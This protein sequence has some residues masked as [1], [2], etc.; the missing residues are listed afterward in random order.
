[1]NKSYKSVWNESTG[2]YV[3]A[4]EVAKSRGK[5]NK[6]NKLIVAALLAAGAVGEVYAGGIDGGTVVKS[7]QEAIGTGAM[8]TANTNDLGTGVAIGSGATSS[9]TYATAIGGSSTAAGNQSI[10]LGAYAQTAANTTNATAIGFGANAAGAYA[11]AIGAQATSS[12]AYATALG[13]GSTASGAQGIALGGYAKSAAGTTNASAIG[14]NANAAGSEAIALGAQAASS[15][16]W[17]AAL[18]DASTASG[19]QS[20]AVGAYANTAAGATNGVALGFAASA[21]AASG[22]A[23][24]SG[25]TASGSAAVAVGSYAAATAANSVALGASSTTTADLT[26]AAYNPGSGTLSGTASKANGEVSVG[27]AGKERRVTNVAAGSAATDAVNVSQLA[28]EDA[29]VNAINTMVTNNSRYFKAG[30]LQ[31]GTDDASVSG[32]SVAVGAGASALSTT[33]QSNPTAY[34]NSVAMGNQAKAAGGGAIAIGDHANSNF[35]DIAIGAGA[36]TTNARQA[37]ALGLGATVSGTTGVAV[38]F[39]ASAAAASSLA[40]GTSSTSKGQSAIALGSSSSAA[41]DYTFAAGN[42]ASAVGAGDIALGASS[43]ASGGG[44]YATALGTNA[45]AI[46]ANAVA[47]GNAAKATATNSVALGTGS[48]TTANLTA[49]GYNPG[50]STL[51][52]TA[53][54]ANGEVSVGSAGKER[55]VTNV[56]AGSAATDAVNVSQ[57]KS[58]DAKVNADGTATASALGGGASYD[59]ST[60]TIKAPTYVV[61][62]G[63]FSDVGSAL[64]KLDGATTKNTGDISTLNTTVNNITNGTAGLVQQN[65]TTHA[66]TVASATAGTTVDFTGTAGT[67]QLKGVSAGTANTDAVNVA[68]LKAAGLNVDTSGNATNAFVA[69][70]DTSKG[71]VTLAGGASGTTITDVKA[72]ALSASSMDAVNGSQ[73]YATNTNVTNLQNTVNNINNGT[74]GLV[75]QNATTKVITVASATDGALVDFTG[76]KGARQL[77]GVSKGAVNASSVD[78]INGSQ[79]FAAS[80][81][82]AAALGGGAAVN[83]DGSVKAPTY[84]I[85]GS[86]YNNVGDALTAAASVGAGVDPNAVAYNDGSKD[87]VTLKGAEGTTLSNVKAGVADMD[88]VNVAQLKAAGLN[89]DDSGNVTNAFVAYDD[90]TKAQVTLGGATGTTIS[91]VKAGV[92]D[93]D[94]VNVSQLK[95][96]D[97]RAQ[98]GINGLN[99]EMATVKDGIDG[100]AGQVAQNTDGINGLNG[101]MATVKDGINGLNGQMASVQNGI[102]GLN[103]DMTNVVKYDD[104]S[105]GQI[106]LDGANGTTIANVKAGVADMDAVNVSQ[107]KDVDTRAQDGING[108]NGEMATVKDGIDGLA[109]QVAQNTDGIN[110]LNGQMASVQNGIDGLNADMTNVVKYDDASHGQISLDGANGTTI[111]NV[112]AGVADMDAVNVSQLKDVD[113]RAQDGINGLNGEMASVK[114]GI[115]GLAGQVAQN[116]DGINGLNGQMASVQNGIDGLNADMTNVVK[117]DDAS[118]G[119]ITLDGANGTTIANV[120]A[121]VADMDAVNVSQLKDVDT[122]AQD[123]ING[124]NG[125][126]ATVKDGIDGLNGQMASV[127]NGI[128]GLNGEVGKNT[129]DITNIT[130]QINNGEIG[131]VQQDATSRNITVAANTD[132]TVV[133][134]TGTA[135]T[136]QLKGVSEGTADTDAVN[137]SQL[138]A[139]G[140]NVDTSGNVTNAFVAYDDA[141]KGQVTLGG[142]TGTTIS[143]VKA[144]VADM[145]AVNVSQLKDVDTRAQDG[146]N[147]L[148]GQMASVQNGID[149]INAD[150]TNVVKY[151]DA[152]HGQITLDGANGTTIANVKAGVADMDAVNVAQLK[153]AGLNTDDSGNVTNAFVAYDDATK[154]QVTLGGDAGTTISNVKAGVADMDAVNVA[155][156]KDVDTR[157]QDGINGLNGEM[158]SVKD[159]IDGLN[160]QMASV[161]NGI[162][163]LNGEV[164]KN[165]GDITNITNQINNGEIGL[166]QQD[167]T[168]RNITVA[169][170][171]DGTVVDFTGTAGTRQLKGVSEGTADTDAVNVAQLKAAGLNVDTSGNVTNAFV[172]YDDA[173]KGQI[174]LG[175]ATGTTISNVKAGVADMDAVN[176]AQLKDVDTRAQ[177]GINGLNGE[178]ASV[179]DGIDGLAGQVAQ[180][181]DGINGLNADM[182]SVKD[183]IN[184]INADIANAVKYDDASHGQITLDGANGTTIANVKAGVA[185]MDAVN[186]AQLKDVDTRAQDGIN[187]LNGQMASVQDGINGLNGQM[188][189]VQNGI[190]GIN[191]DMT[192]VVKYDDASHG[193]ITLDGANG[194]TIS[195]V[196]AG[197]ADMDAVNVAQLKAA[198]LNTD[199]SGNVTN[200]FVAYDDATKGQVTLGGD[201]GTT[202]SNVKAGIAD[203]DAV[204]VAQLKDV[205]TRAQDGIN[206]LNGEMATVKDGI[207]GLAGQVAQNT[208]GINGLNADMASVK[209]GINGINADIANAVKYDDASHGQIS[210]DGAN[211]TTIANVK[212]GVAD[213][214][215][216][217]VS[218]LKDVDTRAQDGINGLNGQMASVQDGINGLNGDMAS[219]KDGING[220]N[221]DM[222]SVKDG[223][224][225]LNGDMA[226]VKDGINGLNGQMASVQNGIDGL[227]AD[228]TNVVK[229]DDA[230]HAQ[231][232]L[233]GANGTTISNVKA[234]VADM[235]A[236]NVAQLK[237]AGLNTDA[238]GNVTN[239]FVAYDDATKNKVTLGGGNLGTT[240]TNVKIGTLSADSTDAVN[241]SQLFA[242]NQ[243]VAQ[244][245]GDISNVDARVT[246]VEGSVTN[247]TNQIN[248]G[249]LGLVQQDQTSHDITVAKNLD[250]THVDF[251]GTAGAREL[252]GVANGTTDTSGVN[253][254]QLKPVVAS[255]GGGATVNANGSITGPTYHVQGG[256]QTTVGGALDALD[257][258]LSSLQNQMADSGIG[259]VTQDAVSRDINVAAATDGLR[260]NMAGT[261]GN[262]VVTGVAAGA[263]NAKSVDAVNGSQL[264][265]N[266]ASTAAALGGGSTVNAD[267]TIS[268]PTYNVGGTTVNNVGDAITNLDGRTTQNTTDISNIQTTIN[269]MSGSVTNA[270]QYDSSAHDKVTLGGSTNA[271]K[272]KLTNLQDADLSAT[273]T[274]AVTGAQLWNTNQQ[275]SSLSQAVQ[276][277]QTS[278]NTNI[279]INTTSGPASATGTNSAAIGGGSQASGANSVAIGDGSIADQDNTVSM[280]SQG[281]ERRIT[282][283]ADGQGPTDAVNMRQFESGMAGVARNAYSGV[284]AATALSM[285]PDVDPNK[286]IAVGVGTGNYK[287]YQATA[288]GASVRITQN[289]KMK[290]GGSVS[291]GGTTV[292]AGASYQW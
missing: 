231:I 149:G 101:D 2:T 103:A 60:G 260:V 13:D 36:D 25:S 255:L 95:D 112:K 279:A 26:A 292:G 184:G 85:N 291:S 213:M 176:V 170:N 169:A 179:K 164:G 217:N 257:T 84:S 281:N 283:V 210:L 223:I 230:S 180:N 269:S 37:I 195:N 89:T 183:G 240:I 17:A 258:N 172:A 252:I 147:G 29:K 67:R 168:S 104:A 167:A 57:L 266:A 148:N 282:N 214:D 144:G 157:A 93:T 150:M 122:R 48:T 273:S 189:S 253:L 145:D 201:A 35:T 137:V 202:I 153:A 62:S 4:S 225:G 239:A 92:A 19:A 251:T 119:Q 191:A 91:N 215:A 114:D 72:G 178:M 5:S 152:S 151:D 267:G 221:G 83:A 243:Q 96:V 274:D 41:A 248:N 165:T 212:A 6:N 22:T 245:T 54:T 90:A 3:A 55:R 61:Q 280:G 1:M 272:V 24:G 265:A 194:T 203:M 275:V 136:R 262:R 94:A 186:V 127:Q 228:M 224:N 175:G 232:T 161:Q 211:G 128:D 64:T 196:K 220:L 52:G 9:G 116:T 110:G 226:S 42:A 73:L 20:T 209:D 8:V 289:L 146:I 79:L 277:Q 111:A 141:T 125:E 229:Y 261:A 271:A 219:V 81:S 207:D 68:Q 155:Q 39:G 284:A 10:A 236:V 75:Q 97:T 115:D 31:D 70:D 264:Y 244:N 66:V 80:Q 129:G 106:T 71:K 47:I 138:K 134:F 173:T 174:T 160:G 126:M 18:G 143:N 45:T 287:G 38:G 238:S 249:E 78:A 140:L 32:N 216:V 259:L 113:T 21:T 7:T 182:A 286:T 107:L 12:G 278:G 199:D 205:D 130:N 87:V 227:N 171:T 222:A 105:H 99:G 241:G 187:G 109:G 193:Q 142:A 56:A 15:G 158:A 208:D 124:L 65:A 50:N 181:T 268:A 198:G 177:D 188:A 58:E 237:A 118:H 46:A 276:N 123:G 163:G 120:K 166:V 44:S 34:Q 28:S 27:S 117:Y 14:F 102:D 23:L 247:I 88:A 190:D 16:S 250:G 40:L 82:E 86:T 100:L 185:D 43:T 270:V 11:T 290:I 159:G 98:D 162:D 108:L 133:D 77:T 154:A 200:A 59:A 74:A 256:T 139:A 263:V 76:T 204:N 254:S 192:N 33:S 285:I 197:V 235:D 121:G 135:G 132:G 234:G 49:A 156:L 69:Y 53:S 131:L 246:N 51:S 30:G 206:G 218:Q 242:T 63:T 233:D 288:L